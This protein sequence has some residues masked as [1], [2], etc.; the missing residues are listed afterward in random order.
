MQA[1][2]SE[3][4]VLYHTDLRDEWPEA[5]ARSFAARLPYARRLAAGADRDARR[6]SL[7]GVALALQA[8]APLVGRTVRAGEL[9][10]GR[11][12]KPRLTLDPDGAGPDFSISHSG[13]WVGCAAVGRG[14]VGFDVE[15]GTDAR[16]MHWVVREA[17]L[18][19]T[20][21]GLRAIEDTRALAP[22]ATGVR[23]RGAWWHLARLPMFTGAA[24]CVVS[25]R[26]L[27]TIEAR[28]SALA[29]LFAP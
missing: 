27:R 1:V 9:V 6:A 23:W 8:L 29:E 7:A 5:A 14:H 24:A 28:F 22:T 3:N 20:G 2:E 13:P 16:R 25:S 26:P 11:G 17:L 15:L 19:A 4:L 10:F 21:E 12:E 18:K